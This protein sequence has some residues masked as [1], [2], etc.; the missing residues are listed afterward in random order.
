MLPR[1]DRGTMPHPDTKHYCRE[2]AFSQMCNARR[3]G[4]YSCG[5]ALPSLFRT[6]SSGALRGAN[7]SNSSSRYCGYR[8]GHSLEDGCLC[9]GGSN[10]QMITDGLLAAAQ[11]FRFPQARIGEVGYE[12]LPAILA[13]QPPVFSGFQAYPD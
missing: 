7:R 3:N 2:T 8:I 4:R 11:G 1:H 12:Q 13:S 6:L 9:L 5:R 10:L